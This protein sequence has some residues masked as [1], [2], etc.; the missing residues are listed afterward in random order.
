LQDDCADLAA[1]MSFFFVLSLVPFFLVIAALVG[2]LPS[3]N[4]W[5]ALVEW[6]TAYFPQDSRSL[7]FSIILDLTD[8]SRKFLSL[9]LLATIWSASSGFVSLMEAL[10][11]A[12]GV[13]ETRSYWKKRGIAI[14]ATLAA[15]IFFV[16]S[17]MLTT[18][19]HDLAVA[20][21]SK[22][23]NTIFLGSRVT[24]Q[25]MRW[26]ANL[27]LIITAIS[28]ANY[29]LPNGK[30]EWRWA[31]PGTVFVALTLALGSIGFDSYIKHS[32]SIPVVYGALA[33]VIVFMLWIYMVSLILLIGAETDTVIDELAEARVSA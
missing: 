20:L 8:G 26:I 4:H 31:T 2:W 22:Y 3:T 19:G 9:G 10:S 30:R 29:F 5:Q 7:L 28:L 33:A 17:F 12:H 15:A 32:T 16:L 13:R 24:W 25:I 1:Q 11:I 27:A 6:I 14:A 18:M 23:S 21:A